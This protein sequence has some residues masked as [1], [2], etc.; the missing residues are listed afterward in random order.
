MPGTLGDQRRRWRCSPPAR[1][2][3]DDVP[4]SAR[5]NRT[6]GRTS[7]RSAVSAALRT[8]TSVGVY[9]SGCLELGEGF[10]GQRER[11][12]L[13]RPRFEQKRCEQCPGA[14][15]ASQ[16]VERGLEAVGQRGS[17]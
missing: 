14:G 2:D 11:P 15:D 3:R 9:G 17:A 1:S 13:G 6:Q 7:M 16:D 8:S 12:R 5:G 10:P 4:S